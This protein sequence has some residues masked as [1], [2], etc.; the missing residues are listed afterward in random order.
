[1]IRNIL[2]ILQPTGLD[3]EGKRLVVAWPHKDDLGGCIHI[4]CEKENSWAGFLADSQD[5]ATFAYMSR[6]CLETELV[7]CKFFVMAQR[8]ALC[9]RVELKVH[10]SLSFP[11]IRKRFFV[12]LSN[13]EEKR[14]RIREIRSL[15]ERDA[16]V[17]SVSTFKTDR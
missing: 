1:M 11:T 9:D 17:V 3:H 7:K 14:S 2:R 8:R 13:E 5:S 12:T 10:G 4:P 6:N 15:D 16:E